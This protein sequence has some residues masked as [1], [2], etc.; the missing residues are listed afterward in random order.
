MPRKTLQMIFLV[1]GMFCF[2]LRSASAQSSGNAIE[3]AVRSISFLKPPLTGTVLVAVIYE[4]GDAESVRESRAIERALASSDNFR[5]TSFRLKR[6]PA[7]ALDQ[8]GAAKVAFVTRGTNYREIAAASA[9]RSIL[10][11]SFDP[12]C[13]RAGQCVLTVSSRPKVQIVVSRA[14]A[15]AARVRFNSS[16]LMLIKEI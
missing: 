1:L 8:L 13:A 6:V 12:A 11:I 10:T 15:A 16:F 3:V 14:A 4:P 5:P 9:S 7:D 2:D